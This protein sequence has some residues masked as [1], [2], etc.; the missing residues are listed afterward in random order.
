M[1]HRLTAPKLYHFLLK[2][3]SGG[4]SLLP[5]YV[6]GGRIRRILPTKELDLA[7][8][9]VGSFGGSAIN[10]AVR[11]EDRCVVPALR[12]NFVAVIQ[13][14]AAADLLLASLGFSD[15]AYRTI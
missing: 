5:G 8:L 10:S 12:A 11:G 13:G 7:G 14:I 15:E 2:K 9:C 4:C 6:R 3:R 1:Y